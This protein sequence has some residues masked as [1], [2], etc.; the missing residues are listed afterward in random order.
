MLHLYLSS[1]FC[2]E[3]RGY[4]EPNFSRVS[5]P[6]VGEDA[7]RGPK[8]EYSVSWDSQKLQYIVSSFPKQD[9]LM[10][11]CQSESLKSELVVIIV[12]SALLSRP[13]IVFEQFWRM[14]RGVA[15]FL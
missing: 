12:M 6:H 7:E 15:C 4:S 10:I 5:L 8:L 1:L 11:K 14:L 9:N 2:F 3:R 13:G